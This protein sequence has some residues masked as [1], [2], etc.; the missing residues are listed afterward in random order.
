MR[1]I[2]RR[3]DLVDNPVSRS[4]DVYPEIWAQNV[5]RP[6][7]GSSSAESKTTYGSATEKAAVFERCNY[8]TSMFEYNGSAGVDSS[9]GFE[10]VLNATDINTALADRKMSCLKDVYHSLGWVDDSS[11]CLY[12]D[13]VLYNAHY[14]MITYV[15]Y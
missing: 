10:Y 11:T 8:T 14:R 12:I 6:Y 1:L 3:M 5:I 4:K 15:V 7:D 13:F 2:Q 9:G